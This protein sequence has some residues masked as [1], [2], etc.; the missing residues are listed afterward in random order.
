MNL[1]MNFQNTNLDI[2]RIGYQCLGKPEPLSGNL[3]GYWSV[4]IDEKTE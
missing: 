3:A 2:D 4:R 1:D